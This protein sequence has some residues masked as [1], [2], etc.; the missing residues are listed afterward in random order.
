MIDPAKTVLVVIDMQNYFIHPE[1]RDHAG[2]IA[3][4]KPTLSV[5]ERCRE[6]GIPVAWLNWG[7]NE[8]DLK[9]MPPAVQRGFCH[10]RAKTLGYGW[11]VGLGSQ[12]PDDQGRCLWKG[13][14][15]ARLYDPFLEVAK[16]EDCF[17]DKNRPSGMW[18]TEEPLHRYLRENQ[19]KTLLFCGVNTDQCVLGTLTDSYSSG[20]DCIMVGDC[21]GTMTGFAA[22]ELVE[23][24]VATN[25]GFVTD[26][27][28]LRNAYHL[29]ASKI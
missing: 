6:E 14:W 26:S 15:N 16:E 22:K 12:L 5:I 4:V 24:N 7:I 19:K 17:F 8:H 11:H 10:N 9:V 28:A 29:G 20:F 1:C 27:E 21:V 2:G 23:Y 13:S 3:A 18:S 25:Y